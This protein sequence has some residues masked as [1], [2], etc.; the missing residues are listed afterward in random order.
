MSLTHV[1]DGTKTPVP[2]TTFGDEDTQIARTTWPDLPAALAY[3]NR[4][5]A[6]CGGTVRAAS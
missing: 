2:V 3:A 5:S 1:I 4:V 6:A